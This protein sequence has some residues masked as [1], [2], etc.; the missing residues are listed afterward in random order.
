MPEIESDET[1]SGSDKQVSRP[2]RKPVRPKYLKD[3]TTEND[4]D[5]P[6]SK[7]KERSNVQEELPVKQVKAQPEAVGSKL[8]RQKLI[9]QHQEYE[10]DD[11]PVKPQLQEE[12][13]R[14]S[15]SKTCE[16]EEDTEPEAQ[17]TWLTRGQAEYIRNAEFRNIQVVD[18]PQ[19]NPLDLSRSSVQLDPLDL[20]VCYHNP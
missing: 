3:Y 7:S 11:M 10:P 12:V 16:I 6:V 13:Y 17:A 8:T 15:L 19:D 9:V 2:R 14:K 18:N 1:D 4:V 5:R 20:T